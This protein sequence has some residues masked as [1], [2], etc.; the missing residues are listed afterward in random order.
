MQMMLFF[1]AL[2]IHLVLACCMP[3][4]TRHPEKVNYMLLP[5]FLRG[6]LCDPFSSCK[7]PHKNGQTQRSHSA[8]VL[9]NVQEDLWHWRYKSLLSYWQYLLFIYQWPVE[10]LTFHAGKM[11]THVELLDADQ[12]SQYKS[13]WAK[14]THSFAKRQVIVN[15]H[16]SESRWRYSS[17]KAG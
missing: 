8:N 7:N 1:V 12:L 5:T 14:Y 9:E 11:L 3:F 13:S 6:L 10:S 17:R 4:S 16:R 2:A 15:I